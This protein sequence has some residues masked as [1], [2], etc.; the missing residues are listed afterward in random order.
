[1][2]QL[3]TQWTRRYDLA[4]PLG[5][6]GLGTVYRAHDRLLGRDV[7]LNCA[8]ERPGLAREFDVLRRLEHPSVVRV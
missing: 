8:R 6:G 1:M 7:A 4:T 2:P 3:P 5:Q